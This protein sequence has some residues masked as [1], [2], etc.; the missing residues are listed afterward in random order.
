M[1]YPEEHVVGPWTVE[2]SGPW[3]VFV[4]IRYEGQMIAHIRHEHLRDL[5]YSV[6]QVMR[7][8]RAMLPSDSRDEV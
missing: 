7:R 8:A 5:E 6:Q 3:P 4:T 1:P 2:M